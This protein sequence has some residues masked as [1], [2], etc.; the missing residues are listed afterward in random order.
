[1]LLFSQPSSLSGQVTIPASKSHT[2]RAI[3]IASLAEAGAVSKIRNPL[4][5]SDGKSALQA[6]RSLGVKIEET[7]DETGVPLWVVHGCGGDFSHLKGKKTDIDVGNSG[8]TARLIIGLASLTGEEVTISGDASTSSRPMHQLTE[9]LRSLGVHIRYQKEYGKLPLTVKG[10]IKGGECSVDATSSQFLSSLLINTPLAKKD[11]TIKV[12]KLNEIPYV[13]MTLWWLDSCGIRYEKADD[14]SWFKIKGNQSYPPL[15]GNISIPGDFSSA[16]FFFAAAALFGKPEE[17]VK[18]KGL[19]MNDTQGDKQVLEVLKEM[20]ADIRIK[21]NEISI[22]QSE[23]QGK[24]FNLN[25]IPDALPILAVVGCFAKGTTTLTNV[26][27]ARIKETDRIAVMCQELKKCGARIEELPEGLRI[28]HSKLHTAEVNSHHDHRV[29][30]SLAV[31]GLGI[32]G[33][34]EITDAEAMDVTFPDFDK[35]M[36]ELGG[37]I[38]VK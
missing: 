15:T 33:G 22:F 35:K 24:E 2:I 6:C 28:H 3:I 30:M 5:S 37:S 32:E 16:S 21:G 18:I 1:M 38:S 8:T 29:V 12:T 34:V 17:G 27:Q 26:P 19:F 7:V 10:G 4:Y 14:L 20:G 36:Q 9:A 13:Y 11:V 23:L 31:A 25:N